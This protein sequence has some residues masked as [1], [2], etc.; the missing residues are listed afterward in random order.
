MSIPFLD[1]VASEYFSNQHSAGFDRLIPTQG[2]HI[3]SE[4]S[5]THPA[6]L[7]SEFNLFYQTER[8]L[9]L[10]ENP[11]AYI[12]W[13]SSRINLFEAVCLPSY[14]DLVIKP[15]AWFLLCDT[16]QD[17][18]EEVLLEKLSSMSSLFSVAIADFRPAS[19]DLDRHYVL[20][21]NLIRKCISKVL[22][23]DST[24]AIITSRLDTDD[25]IGRLYFY[26]LYKYIYLS[27]SVCPGFSG[28]NFVVNFPVGAQILS[29][30]NELPYMSP[31]RADSLIFGENC[32]TSRVEYLSDA[33]LIDTVWSCPHDQVFGKLPVHNLITQSP[34][35]YQLIH[36]R[37]VQN[38]A[39]SS[40]F[41]L[42]DS[43]VPHYLKRYFAAS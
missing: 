42:S 37:N 17:K 25:A 41:S 5:H 6:Y 38:R 13:F 35:W 21:P 2:A 11:N 3:F 9:A 18:R 24:T 32:F 10:A 39:A 28:N 27:S 1:L 34:S 30:S 15:S 36:G 19:S 7:F 20:K 23:E 16:P 40:C 26:N 8:R 33:S 29:V 22:N 43:L 4:I 14:S 12:E 31:F